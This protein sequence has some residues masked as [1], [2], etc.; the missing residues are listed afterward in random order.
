MSIECIEIHISYHIYI[1]IHIYICIHT[2]LLQQQG[3]F[4]M[5]SYEAHPAKIPYSNTHCN[6]INGDILGCK[7]L[8]NVHVNTV[9]FVEEGRCE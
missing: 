5:N 4:P 8:T 6:I 3:T 1:N 2:H 9:T 7:Y